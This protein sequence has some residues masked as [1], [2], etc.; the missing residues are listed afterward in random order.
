MMRTQS[1][2]EPRLPE[3]EAWCPM[4]QRAVPGYLVN[5]SGHHETQYAGPGDR[6]HWVTCKKPVIWRDRG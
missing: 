4:C 2:F 1:N 5:G 3:R 6:L